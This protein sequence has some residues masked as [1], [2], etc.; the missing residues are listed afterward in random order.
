VA[1]LS[2]EDPYDPM[3]IP[4][5]EGALRDFL[6]HSGYFQATV[7]AEPSIDDAHQLVSVNFVI[8]MGKQARISSV[9]IEGA[10]Q[11]ESARLQ[12]AIR[13]LRARLSGGLLK[14]GKP[15]APARITAATTLMK[16]TLTKQ[17][18]LASSIKENPPQYNPQTN[19][20]DVSFSVEVGPVVRVR[21][22]GARLSVIPFLAGR[23]RKKLIPIYSEGSVDQDLVD[24]GERNLIDYF[25]KKGFSDVKVTTDFQKKPDEILITY[26][27]DRGR[28]HK[29]SRI[30]FQGN[31]ALSSKELQDQVTVKKSHIWTHGA[32][33]EKLL[34]QSAKNIEALYHDNGYEDVKVNP[35]TID[36]EPKVDV[37]F[38]IEE[39]PQTLVDDIQ[40]EGNDHIPYQQLTA[41]RGFQLRAGAPFSPRKLAEDRNRMSANYLNR[42]YLNVDIKTAVNR[43]PGGQHTVDVKYTIA[44]HQL[45]RVSQVVYLGQKRTRLSLITKTAQIPVESPMRREQ[46]LESESRLYDLQVFDWSSVGPRKPITDQSDEM[47]LVKVHE[48]KRNELTYGF[49]FEVSHRGGNIP[50]GTV[51]LPGGGGSIGLQGH[52][53]APSQSTFASPRGL[54]EFTRRNMR[55]LAETASASILL[56]RLDQRALTTY[57]QPHFIGSQWSS[58][59]SF[60]LERNSEN[61]LFTAALGDASFQL[62]RV[63]SR[64]TNTRVQLRYDYNK[65]ALSHILVPDLVLTPDRNVRLSTVSGTLIMDTRD[66]PLDAH[67]GQYATLNFGITPSVLGSSADFA[68]FFGQYAYYKPIRS[69]V[70]AN[71][72]RIGLAS[73]FASSF[74]PTSQLFFSGGGTSLRS[75]PIDEAGP[76]RLVPFCNV[77]QSVSGCVNVTVPVGGKQL[78]ILNSEVR[79]PLHIMKALG[80][81]VFYDGGNVYSA[82]NLPNFINNYTNTVGV[83]LRYATP[84]GPVRIDFGHNL[85]PMPGIN[86]NQYY[87]TI[88]QAF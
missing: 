59:T 48:A 29:V 71:S 17:N 86:P 50:T 42:G 77:L 73:P 79:F 26:N 20:V 1:N 55:G 60:S 88:G 25:Q 2:D 19:R 58:L 18:R 44:E 53:I 5:S 16:K 32:V 47:A 67:H 33:S 56:S 39:G 23:R 87:I 40:I 63:I 15:Y 52:Q 9:K 4:V 30:F 12:H 49:G 7:H 11:A 64:K 54:I 27:I 41:P 66:K 57:G 36:H 8:Q 35:R 83:G 74:V 68:K 76:Q 72:I 70:F 62:E 61:P 21:T 51:A 81:V 31:Y 22:V 75:F 84:I 82:I 65:T 13:S 46:M 45:V 85:N 37:G 3:R 43:A 34:K 24:E 38:E 80:G 28:K 69:T 78:F 6:H 14:N 10:N